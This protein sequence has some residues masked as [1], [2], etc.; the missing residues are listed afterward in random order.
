MQR[1]AALALLLCA[2]VGGASATLKKHH[3]KVSG[4]RVSGMRTF[5]GFMSDAGAGAGA[6]AGAGAMAG[7]GA[8]AGA[9]ANAGAITTPVAVPAECQSV[10]EVAAQAG[11]FSTLLAAAQVRGRSKKGGRLSRLFRALHPGWQLA[12]QA[13]LNPGLHSTCMHANPHPLPLCAGRGPGPRPQRPR[14]AGHRV[15]ALRRRI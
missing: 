15:C 11:S 3:P 7:A 10:A 2:L 4:A 8:T 12:S 1:R 5:G 13:G 9:D 6:E 14:P